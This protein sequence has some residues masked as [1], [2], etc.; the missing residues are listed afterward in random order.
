MISQHPELFPITSQHF[1]E[2]FCG[3]SAVFFSVRPVTATLS[4]TNTRLIECY[5][6][7]R[8][9]PDAFLDHF[10]S[11][12]S[13]HSCDFYYTFRQQYL[14]TSA[15]RAAQF[16]YLNRVCFNGIYRENLSGT[17]N[18]PLGTKQIAT[19]KS[20][21]FPAISQALQS[22]ELRRC[23]FEQTIDSSCPPD[24]LYVDP[25]YVT[26]HNTNGFVKYNQNIFSWSDQERLAR[27]VIRAHHRGVSIVVSNADH[28]DVHALYSRHFQVLSLPRSTVIASKPKH[29]GQITEM[30]A[31]NVV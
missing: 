9:E 24:F 15:E 30:V 25:P 19:L 28:P 7:I 12:A 5:S 13:L 10:H 21:N 18:V 26:K 14:S 31:T 23:D 6:S 4:D 3:S 20:D 16:L 8:D 11:Y 2:P 27:S 22:A 1:V 29:R 17:F